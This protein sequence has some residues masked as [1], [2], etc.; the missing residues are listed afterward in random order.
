MNMV[1]NKDNFLDSY[2]E[3]Y[4]NDSERND[5]IS[6]PELNPLNKELSGIS[7]LYYNTSTYSNCVLYIIG[8]NVFIKDPKNEKKEDRPS[9]CVDVT[10]PF[11]LDT[12]RP[13]RISNSVFNIKFNKDMG[14]E[15]PEDVFDWVN[16]GS[17]IN[18]IDYSK[19]INVNKDA[20]YYKDITERILRK[21]I[22]MLYIQ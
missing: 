21:L 17:T 12:S 11:P 9:I 1:I 19:Y 18:T 13:S 2:K 5:A 16:K 20:L 10:I 3:R 22:N 7:F 15:L 6:L 4:G 14:I 8:A